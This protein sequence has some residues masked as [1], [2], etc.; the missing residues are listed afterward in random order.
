MKYKANQACFLGGKRYRKGQ[1]V[2]YKGTEKDCPKCL[3][4]VQESKQAATK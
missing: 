4:K 1:D 2:P 3:D